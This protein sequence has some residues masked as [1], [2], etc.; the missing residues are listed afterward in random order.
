MMFMQPMQ[1]GMQPAPGMQPMGMQPMGMQ[2]MQPMQ[3]CNMQPMQPMQPMQHDRQQS[4]SDSDSSSART[5]RR[6]KSMQTTG[7]SDDDSSD[8]TREIS[9]SYTYLGGDKKSSY[10]K[11]QRFRLC[12][13]LWA[14]RLKLSHLSTAQL[15]QLIMLGTS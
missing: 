2:P 3:A 10:P 13:Q 9:R 7:E 6:R 8:D 12:R 4:S 15:D 14:N 1:Q 5:K 11:S